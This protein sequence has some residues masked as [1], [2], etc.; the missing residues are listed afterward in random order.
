MRISC[1]AR[2]A[3]DSVTARAQPA[4]AVEPDRQAAA[5]EAGGNRLLTTCDRQLATICYDCCSAAA[6][7]I[8]GGLSFAPADDE[9]THGAASIGPITR[10]D[11]RFSGSPRTRL[12]FRPD[13]VG[14][15]PSQQET[16][17][18][19][20]PSTA[21]SE[22]HNV[23]AILHLL[24]RL[25]Y[26]NGILLVSAKRA[27]IAAGPHQEVSP[28]YLAGTEIAQVI[29]VLHRAKRPPTPVAGFFTHQPAKHYLGPQ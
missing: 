10:V 12:L 8:L 1:I 6:R 26:D 28:E 2:H 4:V 19:A 20:S 11:R 24:A 16:R 21:R 9:R 7:F 3:L 5:K 13:E 25:R 27:R 29:S 15:A 17:P 22:T 14:V 23:R 18:L